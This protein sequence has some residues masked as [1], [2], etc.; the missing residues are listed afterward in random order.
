MSVDEEIVFYSALENNLK[1]S[2]EETYTNIFACEESIEG[3]L[4]IA[5]CLFTYAE[6]LLL[7]EDCRHLDNYSGK[8]ENAVA[9]MTSPVKVDDAIAVNNAIRALEAVFLLLMDW[10]DK[11]NFR[12]DAKQF[13]IGKT[14]LLQRVDEITGLKYDVVD[15]LSL[16]EV[17]ENM[18]IVVEIKNRYDNIGSVY[19]D[20][21]VLFLK[22]F[23]TRAEANRYALLNGLPRDRVML[24]F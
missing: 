15:W 10:I 17:A 11:A 7:L 18:F 16:D 8:F 12:V 4:Q 9:R 1:M 5:P 20:M 21:N 3:L 22:S 13:D 19:G 2:I 23:S 6:F 14:L 24:R